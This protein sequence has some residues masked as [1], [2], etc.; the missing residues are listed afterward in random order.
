M[1]FE[2][3]EK[4]TNDQ[5]Q[6]LHQLFQT[7]W[8]TAGRELDDIKVMVENSDVILGI[9]Q[10]DTNELI[11]FAR[12]LTDY[13]YKALILDVVVKR[14][15]RGKQ[16]GKI[17]F[18]RVVEHPSLK[19]VKHIELYCKPEMLPFYQ[20]WGFSTELGELQFMRMTKG[21]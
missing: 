4:L 8:W 2:F 20:R 17:L 16:L 12:V 6:C 10:P 19:G 9:C 7:E 14:E 18:D 13:T 3:V 5:I 21:S 15:H 11:A 1:E